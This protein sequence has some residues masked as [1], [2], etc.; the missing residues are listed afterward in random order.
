V[1]RRVE[2]EPWRRNTESRGTSSG[3]G[4]Q[5][6]SGG[7]P[8]SGISAVSCAYLVD[9][10]TVRSWLPPTGSPRRLDEGRLRQAEWAAGLSSALTRRRDDMNHTRL[11][12]C[13]AVVNAAGGFG[14]LGSHTPE[15]NKK[16]DWLGV[17]FDLCVGVGTSSADGCIIRVAL[18]PWAPGVL[19]RRSAQVSACT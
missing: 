2:H 1:R 7:A 6:F 12:R 9:P 8:A 5:R 10:S 3:Q 17:G 4:V 18:R 11:V 14:N 13:R 16:P 15:H 19:E